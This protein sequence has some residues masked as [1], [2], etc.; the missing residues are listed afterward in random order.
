MQAVSIPS[1]YKRENE[2]YKEIFMIIK[3][4]N[5]MEKSLKEHIDSSVYREQ[6][7]NLLH[8]FQAASKGLS[9]FNLDQFTSEFK[10]EDQFYG[11]QIIKNPDTDDGGTKP[12]MRILD[13]LHELDTKIAIDK[14]N[15]SAY[16]S[17]Y[18]LLYS[19]INTHFQSLSPKQRE[20]M[21]EVYNATLNADHQNLM[22]KQANDLLE[23][24]TLTVL[25]NNLFR[26]SQV[27]RRVILS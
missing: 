11:I 9:N 18:K 25:Q 24:I 26:F 6:V 5:F 12:A 8:K 1:S 21:N 2:R 23:D 4:L 22:N 7:S 10:L 16:V 3:R 17:E 20:K 27:F 19:E 13:L 15:N 14:P